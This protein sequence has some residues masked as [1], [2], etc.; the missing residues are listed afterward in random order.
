MGFPL[1]SLFAGLFLG[2]LERTVVGNLKR[3][4]HF[5]TWLRYVDDCIV[6]AKKG[7]F[8]QIYDKRNSWDKNIT[9]SN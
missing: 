5:F 3:Q 8:N 7:Y 4:S 9:F 2:I 6:I 1:G